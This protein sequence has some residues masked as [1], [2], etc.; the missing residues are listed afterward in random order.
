LKEL[1]GVEV[2]KKEAQLSGTY[3]QG[4]RV[5]GHV[6]SFKMHIQCLNQTMLLR[7]SLYLSSAWN[8]LPYTSPKGGWK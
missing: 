5:S 4:S 6:I 8:V 7:M 2:K 1:A 3:A